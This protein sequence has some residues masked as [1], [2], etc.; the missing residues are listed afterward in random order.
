MKKKILYKNNYSLLKFTLNE[1]ICQLTQSKIT[2]SQYVSQFLLYIKQR[3][4][5]N[6]AKYSSKNC[7]VSKYDYKSH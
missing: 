3:G 5:F 2:D 6:Y 4:G 1:N 7:N